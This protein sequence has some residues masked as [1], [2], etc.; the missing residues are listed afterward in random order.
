MKVYGR[1][2]QSTGMGPAEAQ[3]EVM[4]KMNKVF[5][6]AWL[7]YM[8]KSVRYWARKYATKFPD[9]IQKDGTLKG[10]AP[11][12]IQNTFIPSSNVGRKGKTKM[13]ELLRDMY[14]GVD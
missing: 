5:H 2:F 13:Q 3:Q 10:F 1:Y 4:D 11:A 14:H 9:T 8:T 12:E 7:R 6:G